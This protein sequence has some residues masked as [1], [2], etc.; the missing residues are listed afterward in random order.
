MKL[1]EFCHR[2]EGT[3]TYKIVIP[4]VVVLPV[5]PAQRRKYFLSFG[6]SKDVVE[7]LIED[8]PLG[9]FLTAVLEKL[10]D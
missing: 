10:S 8:K 1:T 4:S 9:D 2:V 3:N 5:L 7:Q 6:L